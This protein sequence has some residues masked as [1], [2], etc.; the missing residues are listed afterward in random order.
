MGATA[1][2]AKDPMKL[3]AIFF[4][5]VVA[6]I[7]VSFGMSVYTAISQKRTLEEQTAKEPAIP[8][9]AMPQGQ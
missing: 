3:V 1:S 9:P 5:L 7:V 4:W 2:S 8:M 6:L